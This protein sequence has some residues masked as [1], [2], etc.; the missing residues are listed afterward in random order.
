MK[1]TTLLLTLVMITPVA[2]AAGIDVPDVVL[3]TLSEGEQAAD[4]FGARWIVGFETMID[5]SGGVYAGER[6]VDFSQ[7]L[8]FVT[9]DVL[10][11][12]TF[13]SKLAMDANV[14]YHEEDAL[15]H[16]LY[17]PNDPFWQQSD[18]TW[19]QYQIWADVAWGRTLGSTAT[20]LCVIDTGLYKAH[21]EFA[22]QSRIAQ[23]WDA[24]YED[25]DPNDPNGHGTHVAGI[26][27]AT[28]N[29]GKGIPGMAQATIIPI[30]VLNA[31]GTGTTTDIAQGVDICRTSGGHIASMS[32][33][34]GSS[35]TI[36]NAVVAFQN[37]GGLVIAATGNDGCA[38]LTYP[39]AY[40]NVV[41]VGAVTKTLAKASFSNTGSHVDIVAPGVTIVST[42]MPVSGCTNNCYVYQDGTSMATPFVSGT[43]A[44][45]KARF[46]TWT[47]SQISSRLTGTAQDL[48]TAGRDNSFGWGLVR[49]DLA[50]A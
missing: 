21:E 36:S 30:R 7:N 3:P 44:L 50:T 27:G 20:K 17:T 39:A 15:H 28:I 6:I 5:V 22:G 42:Y 41:G 26:A 24:V 19:G 2:V 1:I 16:A 46:P 37:A 43:A 33:G 29:N 45:V 4:M 8:K 25:N 49:A 13:E 14:A 9:V 48:G 47:A 35:T 31:A 10:D 12:V 23:G 18:Y 40:A 32:L 11:F 38:C 34:G